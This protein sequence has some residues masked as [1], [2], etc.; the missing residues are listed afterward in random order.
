VLEAQVEQEDLL[1]ALLTLSHSQAGLEQREPLDLATL[2][3][4]IL[5]VHQVRRKSVASRSARTSHLRRPQATHVW[6]NA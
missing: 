2:A 3:E 1:E 6:S 5:L 4:E